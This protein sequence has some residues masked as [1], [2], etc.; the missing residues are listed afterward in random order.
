[1][2]ERNVSKIL[3]QYTE[4][5]KYSVILD[6]D[7]VRRTNHKSLEVTAA[8]TAFKLDNIENARVVEGYIR[9]IRNLRY[10]RKIIFIDIFPEDAEWETERRADL[11]ELYA[12]KIQE[13]LKMW[14]KIGRVLNHLKIL[15]F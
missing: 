8:S 11:F 6:Y 7:P 4:T 12:Y 14:R 2:F 1:M 10:F 13:S 3:N 5:F 15:L 9:S